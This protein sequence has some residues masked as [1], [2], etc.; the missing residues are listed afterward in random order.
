MGGAGD[1][2]LYLGADGDVGVG[3]LGADSFVLRFNSTDTPENEVAP[4][5][6]T[7][8]DFDASEDQIVVEWVGGESSD[9]SEST[10]SSLR[11]VEWEGDEVGADL[12]LGG[13]TLLAHVANAQD[14]DTSAVSLHLRIDGT[15]SADEIDLSGPSDLQLLGGHDGGDDELSLTAGHE[16]LEGNLE[17]FYL[18]GG[19]GNDT[20]EFSGK[21]RPT[22]EG[23]EV[24]S[25]I[26]GSVEGGG[27]G[28]DNISI[29][30][31]SSSYVSGGD[32][33]DTVVV[34]DHCD[35]TTVDL[36]NGDDVIHVDRGS[37]T[38][39]TGDG[40]DTICLEIA[41]ETYD[42]YLSGEEYEIWGGTEPVEI[43]DFDPEED[44]LVLSG[45]YDISIRVEPWP[46]GL[47]ADIVGQNEEGD[48]VL[49]R[50]QGG[51]ELNVDD[52]VIK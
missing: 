38:I 21:E 10:S 16:D 20:L 52:L 36:G 7:I 19:D 32:G 46:D 45:V 35:D 49:V 42:S 28:N 24:V 30:V 50:V 17:G 22:L 39:T 33:N 44:L 1:D 15:A 37:T 3:G 11:F 18:D 41:G 48:T 25:S 8:T 23:P 29:E 47:G 43:V 34:G 40:E 4:I 27:A 9:F 12:Y 6:P 51:V 2:H 13:D 26:V 31:A 5:P 14:G